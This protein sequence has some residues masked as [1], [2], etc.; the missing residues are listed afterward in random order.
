MALSTGSLYRNYA[1]GWIPYCHKAYL[2]LA[3]RAHSSAAFSRSSIVIDSPSP[4]V[5]LATKY[6]IVI[7]V[8]RQR[9]YS[10]KVQTPQYICSYH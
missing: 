6:Q 9:F 3:T 1:C 4:V 7:R 8:S 2:P 5:P 10:S